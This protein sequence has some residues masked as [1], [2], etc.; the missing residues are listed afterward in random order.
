MASNTFTFFYVLNTF[1]T[2]ENPSFEEK[3]LFVIPKISLNQLKMVTP[4]IDT[5]N[6]SK[7]CCQGLFI[8]PHDWMSLDMSK[9]GQPERLNCQKCNARLGSYCLPA[10]YGSNSTQQVSC[11]CGATMTAPSF[12]INL[13]KVDKCS[14]PS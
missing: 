1:Y 10:M 7:I 3:G 9:S 12:V 14:K 11:A 8:Q 5:R 2:F 13:S 4:H 6:D